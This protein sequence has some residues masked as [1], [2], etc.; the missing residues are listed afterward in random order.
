MPQ[1][2]PQLRPKTGSRMKP[3]TTEDVLELMD[4]CFAASA[5]GAAMELGLFWIIEDRPMDITE[6]AETLAIP[7]NRCRYWLQLLIGMGLVEQ[8]AGGYKPSS[9]ARNAI[10]GVYSQD[11][12]ALLAQEARERM[13]AVNNL[14]LNLRKPGSEFS[15][16]D[17]KSPDYIAVMSES[18]ERAGRFTR[19]LY[20][21]HKPLANALAR[22]LDITGVDRLM[23]L[24]GG[25]G[26]VSL[27]LLSRHPNLTALI[28]D[29]ANVCAVGREIA[30]EHSMGEERIA[31]HAANFLD[32]DLPSGFDMVLEC[33]INVYGEA[34][35]RKILKALNPG[36]RLVI[37]DQ[38]APAEGVAP[39]SRVHWAF[40]NSMM[41]PEFRYPTAGEI[42]ALLAQADFQLLSV[43]ALSLD[44]MAA[45]RFLRNFTII[46]AAKRP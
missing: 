42:Q 1:V 43:G 32:D 10:M 12:W 4:S 15:E 11:S 13:P 8:T 5:L 2:F 37:V 18:S 3:N 38:L 33:D 46:E 36:G 28:V 22:S 40:Q 41:T 39:P 23:D 7:E 21:I 25:S 29:I 30:G 14:P 16:H 35:F 45:T 24:G 27:A 34:L 26:V 6:L 9:T 44:E 20:E 19:M 17:L 31:Y